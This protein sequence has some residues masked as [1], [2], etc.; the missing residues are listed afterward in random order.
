MI[1]RWPSQNTCTFGIWIVLYWKRSSRAQFGVSINVWRLAGDTLNITC[2]FRYCNH[3]THRDF[4][5]TLYTQTDTHTHTLLCSILELRLSHNTILLVVWKVTRRHWR[6]GYIEM[7]FKKQGVKML[8]A[9]VYPRM[10]STGWYLGARQN[11]PVP[12][13]EGY[14]LTNWNTLEMCAIMAFYA[15]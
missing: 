12:L 14:F 7:I 13:R 10:Q 8:T 4:L 5:N 6:K 3:Q 11:R 9:V 2:N 1:W 15:L